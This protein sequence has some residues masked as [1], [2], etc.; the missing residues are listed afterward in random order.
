VNGKLE[1]EISDDG[2]GVGRSAPG[3]G[4]SSM[5]ERAD[6]LGGTCSVGSASVGG[7]VIRAELPLESS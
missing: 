5:R 3:V 7:T 2:R 6:E 1:L 4:L